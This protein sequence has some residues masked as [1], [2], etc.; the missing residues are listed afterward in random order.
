MKKHIIN[1]LLIGFSLGFVLSIV[2][3]ALEVDYDQFLQWY[4]LVAVLVVV[5]AV[6][7][8][9][10]YHR[11]YLKKMAQAAQLLKENRPEEYLE[12]VEQLRQKG[13]GK[14]LQTLFRLNLTAG[15]CETKEYDKAL[16]ILEELS[17]EKLGG[18]M[19][20]V[21]RLNLCLVCFYTGQREKAL[22]VYRE[23]RELFTKWEKGDVHRGSLAMLEI[24]AAQAQGRTEEAKALLNQ[25]K[26]IYDEPRFAEDYAMLD[27]LLQ[28]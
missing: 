23:N 17:G 20:L 26:E 27:A 22:E 6:V 16:A 11:C 25:A 13:K 4:L 18:E 21:H 7:F 10:L 3:A 9:L 1:I 5:G 24:F 28:G 15:Y 12:A 8:N 2:R 19:M 14:I